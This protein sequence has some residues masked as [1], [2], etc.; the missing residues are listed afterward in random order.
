[1][2]KIL[3]TEKNKIST[4]TKDESWQLD[5]FN[6]SAHHTHRVLHLCCNRVCPIPGRA[7]KC[8][9]SRPVCHPSWVTVKRSSWKKP[10]LQQFEAS[11]ATQ[12]ARYSPG[13]IADLHG[14]CAVSW[15]SLKNVN[16]NL[17]WKIKMHN[18]NE[19]YFL[20]FFLC[21]YSAR[22][23]NRKICTL[24]LK[25]AQIR[26]KLFSFSNTEWIWTP[27]FLFFPLW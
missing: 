14:W 19:T 24:L 10:S 6:M 2:K 9:F 11:R 3:F 13:R 25:T 27:D 8:A 20:F 23:W 1:M 22:E 26:E 16:Y 15:I 12:G 7:H 21:I 5:C 18:K 4:S 17:Y